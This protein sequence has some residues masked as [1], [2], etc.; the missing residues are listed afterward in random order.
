MKVSET[1]ALYR[2]DV[3]DTSRPHLWSDSEVYRYMDEA[4][5][6][7]VRLTGGIA[8]FTSDATRVDI[9]AGE[10]EAELSPLIL[11]I[12]S[13][14]RES[15]SHPIKIVNPT[16]PATFGTS[17]YGQL[18]SSLMSPQ[19]GTVRAM[20]IGGQ[21]GKCQ[22]IDIPD[23]DDAALLHIYRLPSYSIRGAED[24]DF[25]FDEIGEEHHYSLL[26]WMKHLGYSKA[27]ADT[28]NPE[29]ARHF[30]DEFRA[31]CRAA[32]AEWERYKHKTRVV[33]Y[34]GL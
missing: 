7:F 33:A 20:V 1:Y 4:Y 34:G 9:V 30:E 5:R 26:L 15:D 28:F 19:P 3:Q 22:W 13:A 10:R 14:Q 12:M 27:D 23:A 11:R 8:D 16:D 24:A 6:M 2:Q 18:R 29:K 17:D 32:K 31:Y 25:E 21:R